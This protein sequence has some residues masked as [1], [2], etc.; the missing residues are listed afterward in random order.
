MTR[1]GGRKRSS[2]GSVTEEESGV[3]VRALA[4]G[5]SILALFDVEHPEWGLNEVCEQTGLSKT[6][7]YRMLRT[8][9]SREF[10]VYE[11]KT[12]RYHL[13]KATIPSAYLA[14]SYVNFVR[15]IH[16]FLEEL[17]EATDETVELTVGSAD[18]A[19]VVDDVSTTHPFRLYRP[20]GRILNSILNSCFRMHVAFHPEAEQRRILRS[21]W[22]HSSSNS[23][24]DP[25]EMIAR[26]AAE[27]SAGLAFDLE[28]LDR[29]V[30]AV[31]AP[32]LERDGSLKAVLTVVAPAERF[33]G[34]DRKT[35]T[36]ALKKTARRVTDHLNGRGLGD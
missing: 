19:V 13:G 30:C 7:A 17:S 14:M 5:L 36:E 28:E 4:R 26:M 31:S 32:V 8:L 35:K 12:E 1:A 29:G 33:A 3:F 16:P 27:K 6:T 23:P 11:A 20:T 21:V 34:K 22:H 9:E 15:S 25:E 2:S 18:G 24:A 10:L